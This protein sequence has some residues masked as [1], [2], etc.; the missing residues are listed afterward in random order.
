[1]GPRA[2]PCP[3]TPLFRSARAAELEA[4]RAHVRGAVTA[5]AVAVEGAERK[6]VARVGDEGDVGEGRRHRRAVAGE[7]PRHALVR[8]GDRVRREVDRG[9][10]ELPA[11]RG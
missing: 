9:G 5:R 3:Y 11:R 1:R 2:P 4:A 6:V 7:A 10:V 8:P